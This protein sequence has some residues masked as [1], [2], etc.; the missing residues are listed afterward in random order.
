MGRVVSAHL[1]ESF[2]LA[3]RGRRVREEVPVEDGDDEEDGEGLEA[4]MDDAADDGDES[5]GYRAKKQLFDAYRAAIEDGDHDAS[6]EYHRRLKQHH[7]DRGAGV[8]A[9]PR[10]RG[11]YFTQGEGGGDGSTR[12]RSTGSRES[13]DWARRLR[14]QRTLREEREA[15]RRVDYWMRRLRGA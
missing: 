3:G 7:M 4:T 12:A 8:D 15:Q 11:A 13:R 14:G 9:R 5:E 2:D 1:L 6:D 10:E